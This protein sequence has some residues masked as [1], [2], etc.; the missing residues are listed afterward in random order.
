MN[1]SYKNAI[2]EIYDIQ[3]KLTDMYIL[4]TNS[5][6]INIDHLSKGFYFVKVRT[7]EKTFINKF[8]KI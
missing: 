3:G 4:D 2:L 5:L 6:S 1:P 7:N 8:E